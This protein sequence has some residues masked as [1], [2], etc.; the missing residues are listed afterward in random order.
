[1]ANQINVYLY[2]GQNYFKQAKN[3][4]YGPGSFLSGADYK[5]LQELLN[6]HIRNFRFLLTWSKSAPAHVQ[7]LPMLC[8]AAFN[9]RLQKHLRL[10]DLGE[11]QLQEVLEEHYG[12]MRTPENRPHRPD[13][14]DDLR[15]VVRLTNRYKRLWPGNF[16]D[17]ANTSSTG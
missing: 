2:S 4:V 14:G 13:M 12:T 11:A 6:R 9:P 5:E 16:P 7:A 8:T 17:L 1:M 15:P 10:T 3:A